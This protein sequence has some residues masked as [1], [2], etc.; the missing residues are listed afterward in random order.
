MVLSTGLGK[1]VPTTNLRP[2]IQEYA[3]ACRTPLL[4]QLQW[5]RFQGCVWR[6]VPLLP[7]S[8]RGVVPM[9]RPTSLAA[10][11]QELATALASRD[12]VLL[13]E[14][15]LSVDD[16]A[17]IADEVAS[18]A[19]KDINR[20]TEDLWC[21]Y[22][23]T[24]ALLM[25]WIAVYW[26]QQG[27]YWGA[28]EQRTAIPARFR[29]IWA[30]RFR[31]LLER[32]GLRT[33]DKLHRH[34]HL[35]PILLHSGIP[36]YCLNDFFRIIGRLVDN[37]WDS[38]DIPDAQ[39]LL[40][41]AVRSTQFKVADQPVREFL[42]EGGPIAR[43][44]VE[45]CVA[46]L[47]RLR[48]SDTSFDPREFLV[49]SRIRD[50]LTRWVEAEGND[51][52]PR[53]PITRLRRPEVCLDPDTATVFLQFPEQRL[54][55]S[56]V[57]GLPFLELRTAD[58]AVHTQSL[59]ARRIGNVVVVDATRIELNALPLPLT[60]SLKASDGII[61]CWSSVGSPAVGRCY[62]FACDDCKAKAADVV[63]SEFWLLAPISVTARDAVVLDNLGELPF[64][65]RTYRLCKLAFPRTKNELV[66][67]TFDGTD[68][69]LQRRET[70][71]PVLSG[72][73]R[74]ENLFVAGE[75]V[76]ASL[77]SICFTER[78]RVR[79]VRLRITVDDGIGHPCCLDDDIAL[80]SGELPLSHVFQ[81]RRRSD[82][83]ARP[84]LM[85]VDL[86][87]A[88]G[89][90]STWR[91]AF[92]PGGSIKTDPPF[93]CNLQETSM[94]VTLES[95]WKP[96]P[97]TG[98]EP[99]Q[100]A[101]NEWAVTVPP[102]V[103]ELKFRLAT[104]G[105]IQAD[106]NTLIFTYR[107]P[108]IHVQLVTQPSGSFKPP[109]LLTL[110][111]LEDLSMCQ[112]QVLCIGMRP[113]ELLLVSDRTGL[114][115]EV[116]LRRGVAKLDLKM[117][118]DSLRHAPARADRL[119]LWVVHDGSPFTYLT[120]IVRPQRRRFVPF[121]C[122]PLLQARPGLVRVS[123]DRTGNEPRE[124][125]VWQARVPWA[126][127]QSLALVPGSRQD[128]VIDTARLEPGVYLIG[129]VSCPGPRGQVTKFPTLLDIQYDHLR[130]LHAGSS[131]CQRAHLERLRHGSALEQFEWMAAQ[132]VKRLPEPVL[133]ITAFEVLHD[134]VLWDRLLQL[135]A[136]VVAWYGEMGEMAPAEEWIVKLARKLERL[137]GRAGVR[138]SVEEALQRTCQNASQLGR[139]R[140]Q[141]AAAAFLRRL[142]P[143]DN[144]ASVRGMGMSASMM[145]GSGGSVHV[146][147]PD[148]NHG[149]YPHGLRA[150]S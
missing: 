26:Y 90:A 91:F 45:G 40:D 27:N 130:T 58:G 55:S 109:F 53:S 84:S 97:L 89:R 87:V 43:S 25:V 116:K 65:G 75:P 38:P 14:I 44:L 113:D 19:R 134:A 120:L 56:A 5:C 24:M 148:T 129:C 123:F 36:D 57:K 147:R 1:P 83:L 50:A 139:R 86:A 101:S 16:V 94:R 115:I 85:Q 48:S 7:Q 119:T 4:G 8:R 41:E 142:R 73:K 2:F 15:E 37:G 28:F 49:P 21:R 106:A 71:P 88:L 18:M 102:G 60:V 33:F 103:R 118:L 145:E 78:A 35:K 138:A 112:L 117:V 67:R 61:H 122:L 6:A 137:I 140:L 125:L 99:C 12:V 68:W 3:R 114:Q 149:V 20:A 143:V 98:D 76:Y 46:A 39:A 80:D 54:D 59:T 136:W 10:F 126:P 64:G 31:E 72:G 23:V 17:W 144:Q 146:A 107:I 135:A 70:E 100:T 9:E 77:P 124:L 13:S 34:R 141:H 110:R 74:I 150:L 93:A 127:A 92:L 95:E 52:R 42:V 108:S 22:P 30:S 79:R 104:D 32:R 47:R 96:C 69:V 128:L 63:P 51:N 132:V 62:I 81:R 111:E 11:E 66:L 133:R 82:L 29:D 105:P 131:R 121:Q